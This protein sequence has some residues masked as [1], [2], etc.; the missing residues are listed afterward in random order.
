MGIEPETLPTERMIKTRETSKIN[1][2]EGPG[3][4]TRLRTWHVGKQCHGSLSTKR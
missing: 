2:E 4:T 1:E 3:S